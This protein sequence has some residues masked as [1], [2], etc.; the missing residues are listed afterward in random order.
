[1]S[2]MVSIWCRAT[3]EDMKD[4]VLQACWVFA[5]TERFNLNASFLWI[6]TPR[7]RCRLVSLHLQTF[8]VW[9]KN[10]RL[11]KTKIQKSLDYIRKRNF[12]WSSFQSLEVLEELCVS[13]GSLR[14]GAAERDEHR[15][16]PRR[17]ANKEERKRLIPSTFIQKMKLITERWRFMSYTSLKY[18]ITKSLNEPLNNL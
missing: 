15:K 10:M 7:G 3:N 11:K 5:Y 18:H 14:V 13:A 16:F 17:W 12:P 1:M 2:S 4:K 8:I 6:K 9:N